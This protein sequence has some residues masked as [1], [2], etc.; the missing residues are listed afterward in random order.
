MECYIEDK[1][2]SKNRWCHLVPFDEKKEVFGAVF[3]FLTVASKFKPN[4]IKTSMKVVRTS[5]F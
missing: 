3:D 1:E 5:A 4:S 2:L